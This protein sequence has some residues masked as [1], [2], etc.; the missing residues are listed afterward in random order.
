MVPALIRLPAISHNALWEISSLS[1]SLIRGRFSD[2]DIKKQHSNKHLAN[3]KLAKAL[4]NCENPFSCR[5]IS[6]N[7]NQE[8]LED[9]IK[10][11]QLYHSRLL[12]IGNKNFLLS[13]LYACYQAPIFETTE[14]AL[15][16]IAEL[17]AQ[18]EFRNQ[19]CFQRTLLAAK[20][21][22]S[23][24]MSGVLFIGAHIPTADM[25]AWIIEDGCQPDY[26]DRNWINY[27]PLLAIM[28]K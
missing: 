4:E 1:G 10:S 11:I 19:L 14:E 8:A 21:S 3:P 9:Q 5:P 24:N 6:A 26:E 2:T 12:S 13:I 25:H 22:K 28:S 27:R 16:T 23:F 15:F 7:R 17:P 18:K 20:T